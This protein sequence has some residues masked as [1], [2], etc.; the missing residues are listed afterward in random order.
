MDHA[1]DTFADTRNAGIAQAALPALQLRGISKAF[2][3]VKALD[4]IDLELRHGEIHALLG[5]NGAGKSTLIKI[6]SGIYQP[7]SGSIVVEGRERHFHG[8]HDAL[9]AGIATIF[10]EF[11]LIPYL[12]A[13]ENIFL[14]REITRGGFLQIAAMRRVAAALFV[15]LGF[16][17]DL[18]RPVSEL[19]VAQQQFVEIAKALAVNARILVL[20]EP[21]A[22]LTPS[23]THHLFSVMRELQKQG[24]SMIFISHHLEEIFEIT[25]R[26]TVLR[27]GRRIGDKVTAEISSDRLVEMMIGRRLE[28]SFPPKPNHARHPVPLLEVRAIQIGS[29]A[30][31]NSLEVRAGEILGFAGVVGSGRTELAM[32]LI[33]E[34]PTH[35]KELLRDGVSIRIGNPTEALRHGLGLL[36]EDRKREGLILDFSIRDNL[37]I[38]NL[39]R[40]TH[41]GLFISGRREDQSCR[42]AMTST[43]VKAVSAATAVGDLSGGNQQKVVFARWLLRGCK[44]LI[45]DEPTRGIDVGSKAEIY[46]LIRKLADEGHGIIFI[47]SE[48]QEVVGLCDRAAVFRN[49]AITATLAGESLTDHQIMQ[50]ATGGGSNEAA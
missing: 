23:E 16:P 27:D 17:L 30:P 33:G 45:L 31:V 41:G 48:L 44:I 13:V 2:P 46:H 20:D 42:E 9:D 40:T 4:G 36:P 22:T 7:D 50:Y 1:A 49:G 47:S 18:Q 15:R 14:G 8:Y 37:T 39:D 29:S 3:G 10:Q 38:N 12:N 6:L 19:S 34:T 28:A 35:R 21:T 32:A 5:E 43:Q 11:T 26:I 24:V 25:D